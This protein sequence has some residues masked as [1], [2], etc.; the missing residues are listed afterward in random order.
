MIIFQDGCQR[1]CRQHALNFRPHQTDICFHLTLCDFELYALLLR[2]Q[3]HDPNRWMFNYLS[4]DLELVVQ[5][6]SFIAA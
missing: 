1:L 4:A 3:D 6:P 2:T 5:P